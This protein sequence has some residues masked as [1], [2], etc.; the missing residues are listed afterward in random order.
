[1]EKTKDELGTCSN[2]VEGK[3]NI[4][5]QIVVMLQVQQMKVVTTSTR[6]PNQ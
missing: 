2:N 1:M 4:M 5:T 6:I 3:C